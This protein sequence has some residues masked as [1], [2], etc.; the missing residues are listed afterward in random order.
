MFKG[1]DGQTPDPQFV[2]DEIQRLN[3][4][5]DEFARCM[6]AKLEVKV[7]EGRSGWDNP[8]NAEAIYNALLAHAAGVPLA[9]EQEI[10]VA[11]FAMF[12]Y[13]MRWD[14]GAHE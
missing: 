7:K 4:T 2:A 5:V 11:N 13:W 9:R 1:A 8:A 10:D 14:G 12:L 6:K 3:V